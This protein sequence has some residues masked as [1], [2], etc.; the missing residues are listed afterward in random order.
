MDDFLNMGDLPRHTELIDG[1]LVFVSPQQKWHSRVI[2]VVKA[3]LA[4]QAPP[5][6]QVEREIA[7]KLGKREMPEPDICVVTAEAY[8]RDE[9]STHYFAQDLILAIEA[10]S[11]ES[12]GRDRFIKP[13]KYAG[14]GIEHFWRIERDGDRSIVYVHVLDPKAGE[15]ALTGIFHDVMKLTV[16]FDLEIDLTRVMRRIR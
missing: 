6:W 2:D 15:Y 8:A 14:A 12:A 9:P 13:A 16:P 10:V 4:R 7:V 1:S 5:Q 11:P 3:E